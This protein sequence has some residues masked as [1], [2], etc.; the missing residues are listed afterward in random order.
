MEAVKLSLAL[1][2][3]PSDF[4]GQSASAISVQIGED[5]PLDKPA[6]GIATRASA[7]IGTF[8]EE[9][10]AAFPTTLEHDEAEMECALQS[11]NADSRTLDSLRFRVTKKKI[12]RSLAAPVVQ[13]S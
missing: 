8:C 12:L 4:P 13:N 5:V 7:L 9:Q 10:L 6:E 2:I 1:C 11:G 3:Q